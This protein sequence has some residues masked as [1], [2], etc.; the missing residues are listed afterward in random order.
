MEF[1]TL[2]WKFDAFRHA[3]SV[4][5]MGE[6]EY[7]FTAIN[8]AFSVGYPVQ[9]NYKSDLIREFNVQLV[10]SNSPFYL[11]L[12]SPGYYSDTL[13]VRSG[14]LY[15]AGRVSYVLHWWFARL[16][17]IL[18]TKK[19]VD[20]SKEE[21]QMYP[22]YEKK[23]THTCPFRR[24]RDGDV[25]TVKVREDGTLIS[26]HRN[27]E[28]HPITPGTQCVLQGNDRLPHGTVWYFGIRT[29]SR[30]RVVA[31]FWLL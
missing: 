27:G 29:Q 14:S 19:E 16:N 13:N 4:L 7:G 23:G 12:V 15:K 30:V 31:P 8:N 28:D 5:M 3:S 26:F 21:L 9:I 20:P 22:I 18:L 17:E 2:I 10:S 6:Y 11:G 24:L 1:A 25:L